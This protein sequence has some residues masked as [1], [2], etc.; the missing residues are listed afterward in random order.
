MSSHTLE[1]EIYRVIHA[2]L[3][4]GTEKGVDNFRKCMIYIAEEFTGI[5]T[6]PD[7]FMRDRESFWK[8][9][10]QE[11][12]ELAYKVTFDIQKLFVRSLR[13][14]LTLAEGN[15]DIKV[16]MDPKP[17]EIRVRYS[18]ILE[19]QADR[20]LFIHSHFSVP[21]YRL[22][23]GGTLMDAL[24]ARNADL[25]REVRQR[26]HDLN[27]SL[28][29]LKAAQ[30]Q[31][32]HQEKMASLGALTAGIAHE[33]KN[34]LNFITNFARLSVDLANDLEIDLAN[35]NDVSDLLEDLKHNAT[36]INTHGQRADTIVQNMMRHASGKT[37]E[38][39]ETDLHKLLDEY[40]TLALHGKKAQPS[41]LNY[42]IERDYDPRIST[43]KAMP[44]ELGRVILNVLSNAFDALRNVPNPNIQIKTKRTG[45][46]VCVII[47]DNGPGIEP[48]ISD[49]IFEPFFTTKPAGAGTGLGLSLSYDIITQGHDG[50]LEAGVSQSGGA[51]FTITLP[52]E[53]LPF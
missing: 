45:A 16:H 2:H 21:D 38:R 37:G 22:D 52:E 34:P 1:D 51:M 42:T 14:D 44:G 10:Q 18:I 43:I 48:A 27:Q 4:A 33:I 41:G 24:Q 28:E 49:K 26:T 40:V 9:T 5:G 47:S 35:G 30:T 6:G 8:M 13:T 39:V 50:T 11:R 29:N 32:I 20:W 7:E 36:A 25:E 31:L 17:Q 12:E 23:E 15:L 53:K 3:T 46:V 19:Y